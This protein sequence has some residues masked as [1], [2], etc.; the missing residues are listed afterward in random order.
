MGRPVGVENR[1]KH[2]SVQFLGRYVKRVRKGRKCKECHRTHPL[3]LYLAGDGITLQQLARSAG[4]SIGKVKTAIRARGW[5]CRRC[6]NQCME[7]APREAKMDGMEQLYRD[8]ERHGKLRD[9]LPPESY[10][11]WVGDMEEKYGPL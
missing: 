4:A 7:R 6:L 11:F 3:G 5:M 9:S 10:A 8:P 1:R 2:D